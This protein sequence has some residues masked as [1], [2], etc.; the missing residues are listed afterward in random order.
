M[1]H[2][3]EFWRFSP[4][5]HFFLSLYIGNK[6]TYTLAYVPVPNP[7]LGVMPSNQGERALG[8]VLIKV[9]SALSKRGE[10]AQ[11]RVVCLEPFNFLACRRDLV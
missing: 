3:G 2:C 1:L 5:E 10:E 7:K 11:E 6:R 9:L 4:E 8:V